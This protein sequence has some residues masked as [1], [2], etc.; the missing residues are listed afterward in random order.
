[1]KW[2]HSKQLISY[3]KF[4][5]IYLLLSELENYINKNKYMEIQKGFEFL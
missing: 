4:Y 1:M 3:I 5:L 2:R